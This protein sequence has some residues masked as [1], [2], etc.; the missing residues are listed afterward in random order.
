MKF[1]IGDFV[2][3]VDEPIEG[4]ITSFLNNEL[5]G[6]TDDTGFEIPVSAKQNHISAW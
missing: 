3:F 5:L 1:K 2:R 4:H 6:V